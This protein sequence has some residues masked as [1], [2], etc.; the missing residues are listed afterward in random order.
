MDSSGTQ[1]SVGFDH[2]VKA[3]LD[4]AKQ[5]VSN[6]LQPSQMLTFAEELNDD[7][8]ILMQLDHNCLNNI[9]EGHSLYI[10]GSLNDSL[11]LCTHD[12]AYDVKEVVVS[13]TMVIFEN[14]LANKENL[15]PYSEILNKDQP[16]FI[17]ISKCKGVARKFSYFELKLTHPRLFK[18]KELLN[19]CEFKGFKLESKEQNV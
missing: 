15:K 12:K 11:V 14:C 13:N 7:D 17:P 5:D 2:D 19:K 3:R 6:L 16:N 10:R 4:Y 18:I 8:Y 9:E 1:S